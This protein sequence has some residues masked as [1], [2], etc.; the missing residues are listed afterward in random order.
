MISEDDEAFCRE[1]HGALTERP[2]EPDDPYYVRI[3]ED[4]RLV[5]SDPILRLAQ[6]IEWAPGDSVQ[7]LSGFRGTGKSTELRRLRQVLAARGFKVVLCDMSQYLNLTTAADVSDFLVSAAGALS[8]QL[9]EDPDLLGADLAARSYW[10]RFADFLTRTN[11]DLGWL[12]LGGKATGGLR[13]DLKENPTFRQQLQAEMKGHVSALVADVRAFVADCL[14]AL[15]KKHGDETQLVVL[16]DSI[17]QIRGTSANASEVFE[18]IERLFFGHR[19]KLRFADVHVVY[20]VPPWLKIRVPGIGN[21]YDGACLLPCVKVREV[22]GTP[23]AAGLEALTKI[24]ASRG[25]WKRLFGED[26]ALLERLLLQTGG[27][28]RDLFRGLKEL[29]LRAGAGAGVPTD[30]KALRFV[31]QQLENSYLPIAYA[32]AKWLV[33]VAKSHEAE[34]PAAE[35]VP[36]LSRYFDT[37]MLL[38]YRNGQEWYDIHPLIHDKVHELTS[39]PAPDMTS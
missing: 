4:E 16:F 2:L 12:P 7:L 33:R 1:F 17:E 3:Y 15:R 39:R 23:S 14:T 38:C 26:K 32:D 34:L 30:D 22:D 28:L 27:Y 35:H 25:D 13:A 5:A 24:V 8:D 37:H 11:V 6:G 18:S 29:L 36:D 31:L 20:T 9:A 10:R 21:L 19:D